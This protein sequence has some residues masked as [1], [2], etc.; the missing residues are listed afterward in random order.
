[1]EARFELQACQEVERPDAERQEEC[2]DDQQCLGTGHERVGRH[3]QEVDRREVIG[4]VRMRL[5]L[6]EAHGRLEDAAMDGVPE[7][8]VEDPQVGSEGVVGHVAEDR[9]DAV[10]HEVGRRQARD[11]EGLEADQP[12]LNVI[13]GGRD[14]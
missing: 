1:M 5:A 8:L 9:E 6:G 11:E 14:I 13:H 10:E 2:L 3:Q 4:Q 12:A 7:H